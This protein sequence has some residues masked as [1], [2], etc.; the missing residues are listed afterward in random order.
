M[1]LGISNTENIT[2]VSNNKHNSQ[3]SQLCLIQHDL[4]AKGEDTRKCSN[5]CYSN[6]LKTLPSIPAEISKQFLEDFMTC[7]IYAFG[8]GDHIYSCFCQGHLCSCLFKMWAFTLLSIF[9]TIA[10]PCKKNNCQNMNG[11]TIM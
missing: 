5:L 9:N 1:K 8:D 11:G 6:T 10:A 3:V 2:S 7:F 4:K